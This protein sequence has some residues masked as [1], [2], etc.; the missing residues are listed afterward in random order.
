MVMSYLGDHFTKHNNESLWNWNLSH[1]KLI[2]YCMPII[3][4]LK[5]YSSDVIFGVHNPGTSH[6]MD[7]ILAWNSGPYTPSPLLR[8]HFF[9]LSD[10]SLQLTLTELSFLSWAK[11]FPDLTERKSNTPTHKCLAYWFHSSEFCSNVTTETSVV[12]PVWLLHP[13]QAHC[14]N[15]TAMCFSG[16]SAFMVS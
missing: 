1:L 2:G 7:Y 16:S 9:P 4:Q 5:I 15:T 11:F 3:L 8:P 13:P 10:S 6:H 12:H 14:P